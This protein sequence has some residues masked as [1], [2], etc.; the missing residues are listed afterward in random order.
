ERGITTLAVSH[1]LTLAG[2]HGHHLILLHQGQVAAQGTPEE[3]LREDILSQVYGVPIR[4]HAD[5]A[6][7]GR[8]VHPAPS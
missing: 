3:V 6:G 5:P 8:F 2:R 1:D 7:G 4:V